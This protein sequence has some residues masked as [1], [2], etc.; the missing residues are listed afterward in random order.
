MDTMDK[1][2]ILKIPVP[3]GGYRIGDGEVSII[4]NLTEKPSRFHRLMVKWILGWEWV[5]VN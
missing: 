4:F 3:V 2:N 5:D 1:F